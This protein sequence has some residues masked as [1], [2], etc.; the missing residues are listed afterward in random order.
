MS[1]GVT[2]KNAHFDVGSLKG[3]DGELVVFLR[4]AWNIEDS[5]SVNKY[6]LV[7]DLE[8]PVDIESLRHLEPVLYGDVVCLIE[9][10]LTI[11]IKG[12]SN[13]RRIRCT[14]EFVEQS[15]SIWNREEER[16]YVFV[17]FYV[18]YFCIFSHGQGIVNDL[19]VCL[20]VRI[21][22]D[23]LFS[24]EIVILAFSTN[25]T[26]DFPR[27]CSRIL[28]DDLLCHFL[29]NH[30]IKFK[31]LDSLLWLGNAFSNKI[32]IQWISSF[33]RAFYFEADIIVWDI[34]MEGNIEM[35]VFM[36]K[37]VSLLRLNGEIFAAESSVPLEFGTDITKVR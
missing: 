14:Y 24:S 37:Q 7:L 9:L 2:E 5:S 22:I 16:S 34:R 6:A 31:L 35:Q 20:T 19:V 4:F 3:I 28:Y 27:L 33:N 29:T 21:D 10:S 36:W 15:R 12:L 32:D 17:V 23:E 13:G 1:H 11:Y 18:W 26:L 8:F 25:R 30:A